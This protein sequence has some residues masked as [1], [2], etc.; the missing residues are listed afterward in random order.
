[1]PARDPNQP[2]NRQGS[3]SSANSW[4]SQDTVRHSESYSRDGDEAFTGGHNADTFPSSL[5][6]DPK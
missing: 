2:D 6:M 3:D 1:M 4:R 5:N